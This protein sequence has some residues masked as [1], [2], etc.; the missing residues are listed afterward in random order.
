MDERKFQS[1]KK[2]A[3]EMAQSLAFFRNLR[4][5]ICVDDTLRKE[6]THGR[7]L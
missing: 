3:V 6:Y 2:Q 7:I 1:F 4:F 5:Y